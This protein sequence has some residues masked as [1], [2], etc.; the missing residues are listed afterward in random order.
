[1][2]CYIPYQQKLIKQGEMWF[3]VR[4]CYF[5]VW[6]KLIVCNINYY[7]LYNN[8]LINNWSHRT[9]NYYYTH[10]VSYNVHTLTCL[11]F[12]PVSALV[13]TYSRLWWPAS[14]AK[15]NHYCMII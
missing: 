8:L 9:N 2:T 14:Y 5:N 13:S 10:N 1:M 6:T 3:T 7:Q 12:S 15:N 4:A 11:P